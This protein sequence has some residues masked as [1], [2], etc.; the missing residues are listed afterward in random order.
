MEYVA[1]WAK[2]CTVINPRY[3]KGKF[4]RPPIGIERMLRIYFLDQWHDLV[5]E[6]LEGA[7]Y[8]SQAVRSYL[9]IELNENVVPDATTLLKFHHLLETHDM[10]RRILGGVGRTFERVEVLMREGT[11]VDAT[12]IAA[13][14]STKTC[15]WNNQNLACW[16]ARNPA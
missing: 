5:D 6:A 4:W 1:P 11:I 16:R 3:S 8:D 15:N 2:L 12:I 14:S 7:C 10:T 13:Y 9:G